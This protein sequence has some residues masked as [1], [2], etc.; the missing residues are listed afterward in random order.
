MYYSIV[1]VIFIILSDI[2]DGFFARRYN[3]VTR[4]GKIIDPVADKI[5]LMFVL[6]YLIDIYH[7]PFLIFFILLSIRD[8]VLISITAY[9][10]LYKNFVTQANNYGK[11]FI[12]FSML[13]IIFH[14]YDINYYIGNILYIISIILLFVSMIFYIKEHMKKINTNENI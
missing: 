13:M 4:I 12:F 9:L 10:I 11:I 8:I 2:L 1:I 6:I 14:I 7:L 3:Q 5:C